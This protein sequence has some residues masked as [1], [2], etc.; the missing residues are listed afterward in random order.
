M[1]DT[2]DDKVLIIPCSGIGRAFGTVGREATYVV[3][4]ELR[5]GDADTLCLSL[6]TM[7]DEEA[8]Q[9]VRHGRVITV[10]GCPKSCAELNVTSAGGRSAANF[11]VVDTYREHKELRVP[12]VLELGE[13]GRKLSRFLAD[14]VA[15]AV[16]AINM[17]EG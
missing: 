1:S 7:G 4:E 6:L 5:P 15:A 3:V 14:K 13:P 2:D 10:D 16:D 12:S 9:R 17:K 11:K 8:K